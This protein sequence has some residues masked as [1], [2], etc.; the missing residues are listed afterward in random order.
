MWAGAAQAGL[1]AFG[2]AYQ[3]QAT[4]N[5]DEYNAQVA[6]QNAS[7][8]SQQAAEQARRSALLA[9]KVIGQA[10]ANYGAS[11]IGLTGSALAVLGQSAAAAKLDQLTILANG[12]NKSAMYTGEAAQD[13]NAGEAAATGGMLGAAGNLS[14]GAASAYQAYG[15]NKTSESDLSADGAG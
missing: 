9:G 11:G 5:N 1:G 14:S 13:R 15:G 3:G 10:R 4:K 2:N 12:A 6:E 8:S 7:L